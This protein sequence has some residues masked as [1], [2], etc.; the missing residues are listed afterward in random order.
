VTPR[1]VRLRAVL[2]RRLGHVRCAVEAVFHRHNVSA[3]LRTADAL[4]IHG[5]H[6]VQGHFT[7]SSGAAK[8]AER[9]LELYRHPSAEEAMQSIRDA[10]YALW[11]AD[12]ASPPVPPE[13][14]PLDRPVC[15]WFGAELAG[16]CPAVREAADGV[17]TIPM[18]GLAQSLNVSVSAALV[19]RA[20]AERARA[21]GAC[22]LLSDA[23]RER[24][25][26]RW[27]AKEEAMGRGVAI[28]AGEAD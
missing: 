22:A 18:H 9:W 10:G 15:L 6:L 5:V 26:A 17:V 21:M 25:W 24:V 28:R 12:L 20:V 14:V 11:V 1:Q 4:G 7:P 16:V 19:L 13:A 27:M 2:D 8:G 23:E 3:I